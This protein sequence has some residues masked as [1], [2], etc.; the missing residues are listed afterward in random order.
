[1][2]RV[3]KLGSAKLKEIAIAS[4]RFNKSLASVYVS[5][6]G[7]TFIRE[8]YAKLHCRTLDNIYYSQ[9]KREDVLAA[10]TKAEEKDK[11]ADNLQALEDAKVDAENA[12]E[13]HKGV[14]VEQEELV[15]KAVERANELKKAINAEKHGEPEKKDSEEKETT[16]KAAKTAEA[17][18]TPEADETADAD[19]AEASDAV[20][21]E[22]T[23]EDLEQAK[24]HSLIKYDRSKGY[25]YL[26]NSLGKSWKAAVSEI[27]SNPD[28]NKEIV[29]ATALLTK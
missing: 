1:M 18:E 24:K 15:K 3:K 22:F 5:E 23:K 17:A 4:L 11:A 12:I 10:E 16:K 6:D 14:A 26:E 21:K 25:L 27:N 28:L 7:G 9:Y 8:P 20:L 29:E 19:T 13:Y 2:S